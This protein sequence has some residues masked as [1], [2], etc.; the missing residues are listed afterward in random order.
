MQVHKL[1]V[2]VIDH[3]E[4]G[5]DGVKEAL[6]NGRFANRCISPDVMSVE[7]VDIGEWSD[8]NPLNRRDTHE[9]EV[10]RLFP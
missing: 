2:I 6:E 9:A 7:S 1:T 10:K 4:L 3:D 8:D 5:P